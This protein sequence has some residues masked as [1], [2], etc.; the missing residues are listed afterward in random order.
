MAEDMILSLNNLGICIKSKDTTVEY[1][2]SKCEKICGN[3]LGQKCGK[4]CIAK[5]KADN[6][7]QV[8]K[9]GFKLYRNLTIDSDNVESVI[10][11]DGE[12]IIT[13]LMNSRGII[14]QQLDLIKKFNLSGA[15]MNILK[16]FLEGSSNSEIAKE[17][18][19]SKSTLR[20]H[21]NNIYKKLPADLKA[22]ILA[23][24]FKK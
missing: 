7:N 19:I 23:W 24:H 1:Q 6:S 13:L 16:K 17:L 15:E 2:N 9:S 8:F 18:F 4:G 10:A 11:Q 22:D 21:L 5:L 14:Q 3:Q 20:T 12:K